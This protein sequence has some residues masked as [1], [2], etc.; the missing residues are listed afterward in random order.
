[1]LPLSLIPDFEKSHPLPES[2][3]WHFRMNHNSHLLLL[4]VWVVVQET[5]TRCIV[6][7]VFDELAA[8]GNTSGSNEYLYYKLYEFAHFSPKIKSTMSSIMSDAFWPTASPV[9]IPASQAT[10]LM[11]DVSVGTF[12]AL[13]ILCTVLFIISSFY[14][15]IAKLF[16]LFA[17]LQQRREISLQLLWMKQKNN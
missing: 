9:C 7:S 12:T 14:F 1:M 5:D 11:V 3:P 4:I 16:N 2:V 17:K 10:L 15:T 8:C 6:K 13:R